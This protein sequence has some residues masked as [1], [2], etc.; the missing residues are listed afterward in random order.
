MHH[1]MS[2]TTTTTAATDDLVASLKSLVDAA[3]QVVAVDVG[4]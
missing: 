4:I 3:K 2:D 1:G